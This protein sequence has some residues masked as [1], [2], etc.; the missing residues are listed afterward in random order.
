IIAG[1]SLAG[2][3]KSNLDINSPNPNAA[4]GA[5]PQLVITSAMTGTASGQI[6]N[7]FLAPTNFINGWIGYWAPSGSYATNNQD[8]ASYYETNA[9]ANTLWIGSYRNLED[10]YYVETSAREQ[11]KP[12]YV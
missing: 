7:P 3:G 10:Y 5:T 4:T 8:V 11:E 1:V 6:C 2:C 12:Y 9:F